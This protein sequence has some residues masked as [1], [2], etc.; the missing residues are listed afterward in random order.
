MTGPV[1]ARKDFTMMNLV[2]P[3]NGTADD[4]MIEHDFSGLRLDPEFVA[5]SDQFESYLEANA[6]A[7]HIPQSVVTDLCYLTADATSAAMKFAYEEGLRNGV[8]LAQGVQ[9][10]DEP[11]NP[12]GHTVR[13][14]S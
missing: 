5:A 6:A 14:P 8:E 10:Y 4:A 13:F 1:R 3:E 7:L 9:Q 2:I 11:T 12:G